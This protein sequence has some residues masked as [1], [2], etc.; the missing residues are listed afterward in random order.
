MT[1][2]AQIV[3]SK[4]HPFYA[5]GFQSIKKEDLT[6][7]SKENLTLKPAIYRGIILAMVMQLHNKTLESKTWSFRNFKDSL[8]SN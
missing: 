8:G 1:Q 5:D 3:S 7:A 4:V 2:L 6:H